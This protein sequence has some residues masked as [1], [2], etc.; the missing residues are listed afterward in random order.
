MSESTEDANTQRACVGLE[1]PRQVEMVRAIF[2]QSWLL[3]G[4]MS[5]YQLPLLQGIHVQVMLVKNS[6]K[7]GHKVQAKVV[8][9]VE[10]R[11]IHMIQ[12]N[13]NRD[14]QV[15]EAS[16]KI[17]AAKEVMAVALHKIQ[18]T[19]IAFNVI[20]VVEGNVSLETI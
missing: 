7:C 1:M 18:V 9:E 17:D 15:K 14:N 19:K 13:D 20:I 5:Y 12:I 10:T 16:L 6:C 3:N 11:I 4:K 2:S 8:A